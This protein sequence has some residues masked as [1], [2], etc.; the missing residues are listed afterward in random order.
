VGHDGAVL[1]VTYRDGLDGASVEG[2]EH[3][4]GIRHPEDVR[5]L[6]RVQGR[7]D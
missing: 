7:R 1:L 2:M 6:M 4:H 5:H 3:V